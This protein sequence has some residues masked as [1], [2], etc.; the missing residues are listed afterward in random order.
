[1]PL[2]SGYLS[3]KYKPGAV[4]DATDVRNRH[5]LDHTAALLREVESSKINEVPEGMDMATWAL[6]WCLQHNSVT[7]VIPGCKNEAQVESNAKAAD[8]VS[9]DHKMAVQS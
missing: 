9:D 8:Y 5:N 7:T 3:G 1:V 6:V 2:A 4:F